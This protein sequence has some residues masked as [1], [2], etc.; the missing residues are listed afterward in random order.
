MSLALKAGTAG[1]AA[2]QAH[3]GPS[4]PQRQRGIK[5]QVASL[6]QPASCGS[7]AALIAVVL[8]EGRLH[9][10]RVPSE[11]SRLRAPATIV[12]DRQDLTR[13]AHEHAQ[14]A[15]YHWFV[16]DSRS[17]T[18]ALSGGCEPKSMA[19]QSLVVGPK[20]PSLNSRLLNHCA[21]SEITEVGP[22]P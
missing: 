13:L 8:D 18:H 15:P 7:I 5:L 22:D 6:E 19:G 17:A 9:R 16:P 2:R 14:S 20:R 3:A 21:T 10:V 4:S 12:R 1:G 11:P